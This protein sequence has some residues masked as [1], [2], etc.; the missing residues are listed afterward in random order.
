MRGNE[1]LLASA[2]AVLAS[3]FLL[4]GCARVRPL[5]LSAQKRLF[6]SPEEIKSASAP[7]PAPGEKTQ[8]AHYFRVLTFSDYEAA[9]EAYDRIAILEIPFRK[10]ARALRTKAHAVREARPEELSRGAR[11]EVRDLEL[12]E[13]SRIIESVEGFSILQKTTRTL[14]ARAVKLMEQ[15]EEKSALALLRR[16]VA[17]NPDNVQAW[18]DLARMA[19]ERGDF[20][21]TLA[22]YRTARDLAP[23]NPRVANRYAKYLVAQYRYEE[24]EEVLRDAERKTPEDAGVVLNL[25]SLLVFLHKESDFAS[26][27]IARGARIDPGRAA[28][29]RLSGVIRKRKEAGE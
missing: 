22:A 20:E 13:T 2:A 19:E 27:L 9:R 23:E 17:I 11:A 14:Y 4:T 16:E 21:E 3:V 5:F 24:A 26:R 6:A 15:R 1:K 25:A 10:A 12:G 29:Y 18:L 8:G 28:W 7:T